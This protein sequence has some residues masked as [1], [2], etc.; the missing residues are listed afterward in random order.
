MKI[1]NY[2]IV[3]AITDYPYM[4]YRI[5]GQ[6][7]TDEEIMEVVELHKDKPKDC[8]EQYIEIFRDVQKLE[9]KKGEVV[10][11]VFHLM[12]DCKVVFEGDENKIQEYIN[13][14]VQL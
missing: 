11:E 9:N 12:L 8:Y 10:A 2:K 4:Q 3:S 6:F 5:E 14:L 7:T 1:T 13:W